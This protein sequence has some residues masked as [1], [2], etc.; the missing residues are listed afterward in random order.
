M[1]T[2]GCDPAPVGLSS[3]NSVRNLEQGLE[4]PVPDPH[5]SISGKPPPAGCG[6]ATGKPE[7]NRDIK[8]YYDSVAN[9]PVPD[10]IKALMA[11]LAQT[12]RK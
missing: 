1:E 7:W 5:R 2:G 9:E 10:A 12:I 11:K 4:L 8:A 6:D 3:C